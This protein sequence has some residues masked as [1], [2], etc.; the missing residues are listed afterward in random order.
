MPPAE[1]V[2]LVLATT[3]GTAE[4]AVGSVTRVFSLA[5]A[6]KLIVATPEVITAFLVA[7]R[8]VESPSVVAYSRFLMRC[9]VMF[10][11]L[12]SEGFSKTNGLLEE[13]SLYGV[14]VTT[15]L[16]SIVSVPVLSLRNRFGCALVA[17]LS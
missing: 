13:S 10:H 14:P 12:E 1:L 7:V 9:A 6:E 3:I 17:V 11:T 5:D 15:K 8:E 2:E 4:K 16:P